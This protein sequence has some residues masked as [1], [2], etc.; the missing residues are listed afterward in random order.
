M[1]KVLIVSFLCMGVMLMLVGCG[2]RH[3]QS[4]E[5]WRTNKCPSAL[6]TF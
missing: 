4:L 2:I 6:T 1:V 3:T 5:I